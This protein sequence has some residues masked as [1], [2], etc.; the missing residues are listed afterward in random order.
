MLDR[1]KIVE[2]I[3]QSGISGPVELVRDLVDQAQGRPGLAVTLTFLCLRGDV[4]SVTLSDALCKNIITTFQPLIGDDATVILASF[5]I[6]GESGMTMKTVAK[7]LDTSVINV[8]RSVTMLASG[9]VVKEINQDLLAV[10]PAQLRFALVR[11]VFFKGATSLDPQNLIENS[12]DYNNTLITLIGAK[13]RG[14]V[15]THAATVIENLLKKVWPR[16]NGPN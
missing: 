1:D 9:G 8:H 2:V 5:A 10:T 6:G 14:A 16:E 15:I 3:K 13:A 4:Q 7:A 12:S 11:D